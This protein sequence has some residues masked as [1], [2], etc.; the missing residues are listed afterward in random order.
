V[1][2]GTTTNIAANATGLS[3][4]N[5]GRIIGDGVTLNLTG[6][7]ITITMAPGCNAAQANLKGVS[8]EA[9]GSIN[10]TNV[11]IQLHGGTNA[12]NN[13]GAQAIGGGIRRM[14]QHAAWPIPAAHRRGYQSARQW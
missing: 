5:V 6:S 2:P 12:T 4:S 9:G 3:A 11:Q 14:T 10:L 13:Y 1:P 8:A 7:G